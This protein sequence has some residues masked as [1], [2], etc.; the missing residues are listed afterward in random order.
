MLRLIAPSDE[1]AGGVSSTWS[2][3]SIRIALYK[4]P[5]FRFMV[6]LD[7]SW[8]GLLRKA[9]LAR[10]LPAS[11]IAAAY[12]GCG[13]FFETFATLLRNRWAVCLGNAR[14]VLSYIMT[15]TELMTVL[16][17]ASH[18]ANMSNGTGTLTS[19]YSSSA[20]IQCSC[21]VHSK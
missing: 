15:R 18:A 2:E 17:F 9:E 16:I 8:T 21:I 12:L 11:N 5:L 6:V 13:V 3:K 20:A 7:S 14:E 19:K 1:P 4:W 10:V